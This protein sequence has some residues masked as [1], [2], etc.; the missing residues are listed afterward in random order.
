MSYDQ[1]SDSENIRQYVMRNT[2]GPFNTIPDNIED[3]V[4]ELWFSCFMGNL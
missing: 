2:S 1:S 4:K 3:H